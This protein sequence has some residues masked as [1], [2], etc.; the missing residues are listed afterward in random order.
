MTAL[1]FFNDFFQEQEDVEN[2]Q[3]RAQIEEEQKQNRHGGT[4]GTQQ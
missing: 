1:N 3:K 4:R 2:R